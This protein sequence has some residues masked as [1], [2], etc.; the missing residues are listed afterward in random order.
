MCCSCRGSQHPHGSLL[1]VVT[2]FP[3]DLKSS[4]PLGPGTHGTH[5]CI[6]AKH[7]STQ[8]KSIKKKTEHRRNG[9]VKTYEGHCQKGPLKPQGLAQSQRRWLPYLGR[10]LWSLRASTFQVLY[11]ILGFTRGPFSRDSL[12]LFCRG[13]EMTIKGEVRTG[14]E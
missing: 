10:S 5:T 11:A 12:I 13:P 7:S 8:N 9:E 3:G 4:S 14:E 6:Q 1:T 2:L